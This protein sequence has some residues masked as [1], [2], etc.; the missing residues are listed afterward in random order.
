MRAPKILLI[1]ENMSDKRPIKIKKIKIN[2]S[3]TVGVKP[4][5]TWYGIILLYLK[6]KL[7]LCLSASVSL[8]SHSIWSTYSLTL[9]NGHSLYLCPSIL[10]LWVARAY[11]GDYDLIPSYHTFCVV[12]PLYL[13][14]PGFHRFVIFLFL[15]YFLNLWGLVV[16]IFL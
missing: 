2:Q 16:G 9:Q 11:P 8:Q 13:I 6:K 1:W 10:W 12:V 7:P 4:W 15:I 3:Q 5:F 14:F